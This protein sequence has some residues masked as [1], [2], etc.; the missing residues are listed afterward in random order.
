MLHSFRYL[1]F[2]F[3]FIYACVI[4]IRNIFFDRKIISS[5]SFN[6]PII[7]IGNLAMGG[8]GKTPMVE[9]IL[10]MLKDEKKVA[11]L[12]RGYMRKSKGVVFAGPDCTAIEIG[13]EPMQIH[14]KFPDV[15]LAVAE[16][17]L[18]GIPQ[19]LHQYPQTEL[20]VLDD[21]FQHRKVS[22]GLNIILTEYFN[23][24]TRDYMFP[25]GDLRDERKSSKRADVIVVTKSPATMDLIT[26]EKVCREVKTNEHQK[27]FFTTISYGQPYHLITDESIKLESDYHVLL[28]SG[29]ANPEP[30][31]NHLTEKVASFEMLRYRDHH[32]FT[33]DDLD[34]IKKAFERMTEK[35]KI[36]VTTEKDAVRLIKYKSQIEGF[37]IYVLPIKH[38]FHDT[39]A[40]ELKGI[41][42]D[43][44]NQTK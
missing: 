15:V 42:L 2:P 12:S 10:R 4:R 36:V 41:L 14:Q 38:V 19:I 29:I 33:L 23:L 9:E 43:F 13:D 31:K 24:F 35:K 28:I 8:T 11:V 30:L 17:R 1:L 27:V 44:I 26:K 6:F 32:I 7:C 25:V 5:A 21:A 20:I 22:A 37:P 34:D 39:G 18:V 16:E 3:S 40:Q